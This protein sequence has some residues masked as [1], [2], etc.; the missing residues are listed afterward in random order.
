MIDRTHGLPLGRQAALL[1]LSRSS[2]Y[3][4]PQPVPQC[5]SGNFPSL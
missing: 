4:E 1:R 5:P 2:L 3:Y